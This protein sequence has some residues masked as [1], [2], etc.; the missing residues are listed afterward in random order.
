MDEYF[1]E[2]F[3]PKPDVVKGQWLC[4]WK[5]QGYHVLR[6]DIM[7]AR[8]YIAVEVAWYITDFPAKLRRKKASPFLCSGDPGTC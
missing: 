5:L 7:F 8:K 1:E 3:T 4:K 2:E 6:W